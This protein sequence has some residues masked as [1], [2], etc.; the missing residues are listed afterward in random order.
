MSRQGN[1]IGMTQSCKQ[2]LEAVYSVGS[3]TERVVYRSGM[4]AKGNGQLE[5]TL[6]WGVME[7]FLG[8]CVP[9]PADVHCYSERKLEL[10]AIASLE[11]ELT[12]MIDLLSRRNRESIGTMMQ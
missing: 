4:G 12:T 7:L 2:F 3:I 5:Q 8:D 11:K 6:L 1:Y 9:L 10:G